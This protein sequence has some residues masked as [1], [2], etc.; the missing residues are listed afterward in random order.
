ME[1]AVSGPALKAN[2]LS[3]RLGGAPVVRDVELALFS[4]QWCGLVGANG[5]GKTTLLRCLAGRLSQSTGEIRL[6]GKPGGDDPER[7]ARTTGLGPLLERLPKGLTPAELI[8]VLEQ[9]HGAPTRDPAAEAV[10]EALA[11]AKL[12]DRPIGVMSAGQRQRISI[13]CAFVGAP[14]VVLLDEPFNW[15]DPAVAHDLKTALRAIA[16]EHGLALLTALHDTATLATWC[17][18]GLLMAEGRIVARFDQAALT[19]ARSDLAGF[20][21]DLVARLRRPA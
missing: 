19:G 2:G 21:A 12:K 3:I 4:G 11:F 20:E 16:R 14:S 5:S 15:L 10:R 13:C 9:A 6:H 1:R 17:D 18:H 8:Q 7:R